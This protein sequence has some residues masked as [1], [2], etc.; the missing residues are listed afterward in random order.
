MISNELEIAKFLY[1]AANGN[2][3]FAIIKDNYENKI[4][5]LVFDKLL[6]NSVFNENENDIYYI[7]SKTKEFIDNGGK[8]NEEIQFEK[9][10]SR[11]D[12][13]EL[14]D[15]DTIKIAKKSFWISVCALLVSFLAL[16]LVAFNFY[17]THFK[18]KDIKVQK[19]NKTITKEKA[20][21]EFNKIQKN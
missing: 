10:E 1:N 5:F 4:D 11:K 19:N 6:R 13:K 20:K 15:K 7:T 8:T 21:K 16:S 17:L 2:L 18:T 14:L 12:R 3:T 9:E